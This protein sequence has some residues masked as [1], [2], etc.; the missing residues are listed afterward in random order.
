MSNKDYTDEQLKEKYGL[1]LSGP[2]IAILDAPY[3]L[4]F[5][6]PKGH[7]GKL[8]TWSEFKNDIWCYECKVDYLSFDCPIQRPCWMGKDYWEKWYIKGDHRF[9]IL[10]GRYHPYSDCRNKYGRLHRCAL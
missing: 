5:F 6:C 10:K 1:R 9:I 4:G 3:E 8:I 7:G 2:G